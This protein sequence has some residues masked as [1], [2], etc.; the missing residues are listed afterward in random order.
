MGD[1]NWGKVRRWKLDIRDYWFSIFRSSIFR[2]S[3]S[4]HPLI[5]V[6][7]KPHSLLSR[8]GKIAP[9]KIVFWVLK[10]DN[11]GFFK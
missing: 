1:Q 2:S 4:A 6:N 8:A 5:T 7:S 11:I 9:K 3:I 10:I